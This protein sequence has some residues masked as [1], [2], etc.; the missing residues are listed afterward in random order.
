[1]SDE[2]DELLN[3]RSTIDRLDEEILDRPRAAGQVCPACREIKQGSITGPERE[4]QVLRRLADLNPGPLPDEAVQRIFREVMSHCLALE[5][6][7]KVGLSRPAGTF[8]GEALRK[9]FGAPSFVP[10][11]TIDEVFRAVESGNLDYGWCLSKTRPRVRSAARSTCCSP[12]R[13]RF[14]ARSRSG[15]T[16]IC[17]RAPMESALPS[18]S[19]RIRNRWPSATNGSTAILRACRE[20]RLRAT[21]RQ[22]GWLPRTASRAIAGEAAAQLYGLNVLAANIEDDP[23]NS[24]RFLVISRHESG[25]SKDKTSIVFCAE[26]A[27]AMHELLEPIARFG[28]DMTKLR[29]GPRG[30]LW[31]VCVLC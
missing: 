25:P 18:G 20:F 15:F 24:T 17:S 23:N 8:S 11:P 22:P 16:S 29:R 3:L 30:G 13:C 4:A 21:P 2:R 5:R 19:I 14:A 1:M 7:L 10:M 27:G 31:G 12:T 28:V 6:P 26:P 9:H